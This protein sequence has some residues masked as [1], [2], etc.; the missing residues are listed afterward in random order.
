MIIQISKKS[1]G[2]EFLTEIAGGPTG[3][4]PDWLT[5]NMAANSSPYRC[6]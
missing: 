6:P 1:E 4:G 5:G 2:T 3:P